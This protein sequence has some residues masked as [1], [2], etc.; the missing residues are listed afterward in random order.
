MEEFVIERAEVFEEGDRLF[1]CQFENGRWAW[2]D[3][4]FATTYS[5]YVLAAEVAGKD[6]GLNNKRLFIRAFPEGVIAKKKA[7]LQSEKNR[8]VE[9]EV[10]A[11]AS[12][13]GL[14][15]RAANSVAVGIGDIEV[16]CYAVESIAIGE[17]ISVFSPRVAKIGNAVSF[18]RI[19]AD[20][21][22]I[23][24]SGSPREIYRSL[25]RALW[26]VSHKGFAEYLEKNPGA[27]P[28]DFCESALDCT[29]EE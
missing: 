5:S 15:N 14:S 6:L 13:V 22:T 27:K 16:G 1:V 4:C 17:D 29:R 19:D 12:K 3:I 23:M 11:E 10:G 7:L 28:K 8:Q 2:G 9:S 24:V 20:T 18:L 25:L 26:V 21:D